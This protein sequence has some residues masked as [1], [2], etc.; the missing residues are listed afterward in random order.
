[1]SCLDFKFKNQ[2]QLLF[3]NERKRARLQQNITSHELITRSTQRTKRKVHKRMQIFLYLISL[4]IFIIFVVD[5]VVFFLLLKKLNFPRFRYCCCIFSLS[6]ILLVAVWNCFI[7]VLNLCNEW[8]SEIH[9]DREQK[10]KKKE[11]RGGPKRRWKREKEKK[12]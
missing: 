11:R 6:Y 4:V 10:K 3:F 1:M 12:T 7:D 9:R 2:Q 5:V 8:Y